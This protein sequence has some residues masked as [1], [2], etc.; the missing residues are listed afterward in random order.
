MPEHDRV[1]VIQEPAGHEFIAGEQRDE[2]SPQQREFAQPLAQQQ[3]PQHRTQGGL[4]DPVHVLDDGWEFK[5]AELEMREFRNDDSN[6]E[7]F[8]F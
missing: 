2:C 7:G 8:S 3:L 6:D 1:G 4:R 5:I